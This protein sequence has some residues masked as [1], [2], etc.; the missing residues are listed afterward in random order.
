MQPAVGDAEA[1]QNIKARN[2]RRSLI[3][4]VG[5]GECGE[6][7]YR[8][9]SSSSDDATTTTNSGL[10][11]NNHDLA[12]AK[13]SDT[14]LPI[15][16][17]RG[18]ELA[19]EELSFNVTLPWYIIC[20]E[21][22]FKSR[23]DW[24]IIGLVV[25][26]SALIPW[27]MAFT[28]SDLPG[29][30]VLDYI[31]DSV[32]FVD[33][34]LNFCHAYID[35]HGV[36]VVDPLLVR[37]NYLNTWFTVDFLG[38][39][40]FEVILITFSVEM[41]V[42]LFNLFKLPRLLRLGRL[43]KKLDQLSGAN[44]LR[45]LKLMF[46]FA[47]FAHW[48]ACIWFYLGRFQGEGNRWTGAV[49]LVKDNLC[50]TIKGPGAGE[51]DAGTLYSRYG[52]PACIYEVDSFSTDT[53]EWYVD[54]F[55]SVT[56]P[57]G[58]TVVITPEADA[59]TV[60]VA[61]F[62]F[63]LTTL[64]TVGYG[65]I[66]PGTNTERMFAIF[67]MLVGAIVYASIFG[68]VMALIQ[69]FDQMNALH[70][71][72][73][74]RLKAFAQF[75]DIKPL[76]YEK[77]VVYMDKTYFQTQGFDSTEILREFPHAFRGEILMEM[78]AE[79]IKMLRSATPYLARSEMKLFVGALISNLHPQVVLEGDDIV[80][81]GEVGHEMYF[82]RRG[83][84]EIKSEPRKD[85][86]RNKFLARI[87]KG[88]SN[89]AKASNKRAA[90]SPESR[91]SGEN[92]RAGDENNNDGVVECFDSHIM[93]LVEGA[94]PDTKAEDIAE[95]LD[96]SVTMLMGPGEHFGEVTLFT[97]GRR[98]S[99]VSA[100]T[101]CELFSLDQNS[102]RALE[103]D[104]SEEVDTM[105]KFA[106]ARM[107]AKARRYAVSSNPEFAEPTEADVEREVT[108]MSKSWK[109][110]KRGSIFEPDRGLAPESSSTAVP[111]QITSIADAAS[112]LLERA[113]SADD[114][115]P[116]A[117]APQVAH[118]P[119]DDSAME[120]ALAP[121]RERV[122]IL[123]NQLASVSKALADVSKSVGETKEAQQAGQERIAYKLDTLLSFYKPDRLSP[124]TLEGL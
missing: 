71:E 16:S 29:L 115:E 83:I 36:E 91:K 113:K 32:F 17:S 97:E 77:M 92:E 100:K 95:K 80:R 27:S 102:F 3:Q 99:S 46:F 107:E 50:Q 15:L 8:R 118:S 106:V 55:T 119:L 116:S 21:S 13:A 34:I 111:P 74:D 5:N 105:K 81:V 58:E 18:L 52:H 112:M 98:Q 72:K 82:I 33:I 11:A 61:S 73:V 68:N 86:D 66:T 78:H 10:D 4:V 42:G 123:E 31:I 28:T 103:R 7:E 53:K 88:I 85:V 9:K 6:E 76:T 23:W 39:F 84:V 109:T 120:R 108:S 19:D 79:F 110:R 87:K 117:D 47:L 60:Y 89:W 22:V 101:F 40:P 62:Y 2:M 25:Y 65:D 38:F 26:N 63:A 44:V 124:V 12:D 51:N 35:K 56:T 54:S 94:N 57:T 96:K 93:G 24:F 1:A 30:K 14:A 90:K 67:V 49:W 43:M 41:Q 122:A 37:K 75:Y 121:V 104:Y 59:G 64:T 45:I 114:A 69:S 20:A 48:I 70:T